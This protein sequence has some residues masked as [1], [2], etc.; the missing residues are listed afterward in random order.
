MAVHVGFILCSIKVEGI[1]NS[2]RGAKEANVVGVGKHMIKK[3]QLK[4]RFD[5]W[6]VSQRIYCF[7][8]LRVSS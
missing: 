8:R 1:G 3:I 6:I 2:L 5:E 7:T 4:C